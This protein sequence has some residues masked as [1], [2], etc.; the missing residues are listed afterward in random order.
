VPG[1]EKTPEWAV[2]FFLGAL[3]FFSCSNIT[4]DNLRQIKIREVAGFYV[5]RFI[6]LPIA[7]YGVFIWLMP[8]FAHGVLL[9]A[10]MPAG[11]AAGAL[12]GVMGG[13][14]AL[15]LSLTVLSGLM[16]PMAVP[17]V[18]GLIGQD[19]S[20][21]IFAM[22]QTLAIVIL[23]PLALYFFGARHNAPVKQWTRAN[24]KIGT[25]VFLGLMLGVVIA[26][27]KHELFA[28]P[29]YAVLA[30]IVLVPLFAV[31]YGAGWL[32]AMRADRRARISFAVS[33]GAMN[34]ALAI[35]LALLYFPPEVTLFVVVSEIPW[36]L[37]LPAFR[38]FLSFHENRT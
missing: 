22:A 34:N 24:S 13:N 20:L 9:L 36:F 31:F 35:S 15:G 30:M 37:A 5:L 23:V 14:V 2:L 19:L 6:A 16:A 1:L 21:D 26:I 28:A 11:V 18:Y 12:C 8:E 27:Q 33:S 38:R 17:A 25:T 7:L 32:I 29:Q 10:L 3:I 4:I